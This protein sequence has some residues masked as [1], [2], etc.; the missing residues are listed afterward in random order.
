MQQGIVQ[1]E[2]ENRRLAL[3]LAGLTDR[4]PGG[5]DQPFSSQDTVTIGARESPNRVKRK[6]QQIFEG[7]IDRRYEAYCREAQVFFASVDATAAFSVYAGDNRTRFG[8]PTIVK[9]RLLAD[10][11]SFGVLLPLNR[12]RHWSEVVGLSQRDRPYHEKNDTLVWRGVTTGAFFEQADVGVARSRRHLAELESLSPGIDAKFTSLVQ[13]GTAPDPALVARVQ[14][15]MAP[16]LTI[17][18]Q[19]ASKFLLSLEGNDVAS[20]LKWMMAS[21]S[22]VIMPKPTCESWFCEGELVPWVHYVPVRH[23]LADLNEVYAWC[24]SHDDTCHGIAQAGRAYA[25]QFVDGERELALARAVVR[26]YLRCS[27]VTLEYPL[28][29]RLRQRLN[30]RSL[31]REFAQLRGWL[32]ALGEGLGAVPE[33]LDTRDAGYHAGGVAG[34]AGDVDRL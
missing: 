23:D 29:E 27:D 25:A 5:A 34:D 7:A 4:E 16:P 11:D 12:M 13:Q 26:G 28:S 21:N 20:G 9:S 33:Q 3:Y 24:L 31:D 22:T 1:S 18:E 10:R 8:S 6:L 19:L 17:E 32:D 30:G 2:F 15:R 14:A